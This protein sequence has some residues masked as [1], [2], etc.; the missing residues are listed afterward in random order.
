MPKVN[1]STQAY[2]YLSRVVSK[3]AT[4]MLQLPENELRKNEREVKHWQLINKKLNEV[5]LPLDSN[6][7]LELT[8][9]RVE[10]KSLQVMVL[11]TMVT[12]QAK[13]IPA[14]QER[15]E[16]IP[17]KKPF[18]Q[19]YVRKSEALFEGLSELLEGINQGMKP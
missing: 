3:R 12:L 16:K 15:M 17:E 6:M 7:M 1:V 2:E 11:D 18:Y 9:K 14:Y 10:L 5:Q 8:F 19:E 13:T 4:Q